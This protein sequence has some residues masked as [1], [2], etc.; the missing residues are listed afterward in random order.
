MSIGLYIHIPFCQRKCSYCDFPSY[1]GYEHL[2]Q[3]Y[4]T[5]LCREIAGRGGM[6]SCEQ[7][8]TLY[9]GGGTPT[10]LS[11]PQIFAIVNCLSQHWRIS[12]SAEFS[13][14]ANPGTV[15]L[16][17]LSFL[18]SMGINRISFGVQSFSDELLQKLG[19][20]H[21]SR[22]AIEV[23]L[24]AQ[25]AGFD[26]IN[27]DLMSGLPGQTPDDWLATLARAS[28]LGIQHISAY[29]L[30]IEEGT[31]F[32]HLHKQCRLVLPTD[33]E[34]ETMYDLT[35]EYLPRHGFARYEISN[36]ALPGRECLHN[37]KYWH[38]KPYI[39]MGAGAH[40][41]EQGKRT[42]NT[43]NVADYIAK[44]SQGDTPAIS[45]E[46]I[47][48]ADSMAEFVF[49]ALRTT[50]GVWFSD[51][52]SHFGIDFREHF[53]GPAAELSKSGLLLMDQERAFLTPQ[54]MKFG[55]AAFLA[56]LPDKA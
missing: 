22:E 47:N 11:K 39:G 55:N 15:D 37:L 9:I 43:A 42:A 24:L 13:M 14:E 5:A 12:D 16:D 32:F 4:I 23:V 40:S 6:F 29:G 34:D 52:E 49:L 20:V 2:Y 45:E 41:F 35:V 50:Q 33:E 17:K 10:L 18:R 30:K 26:N 48:K 54:G 31:P 3:D 1:A 27:V 8:D 36:Y 19:R 25:Q 53:V 56:F 38:Y 7:V 51:F 28:Q 44:I 46:Y 21:S